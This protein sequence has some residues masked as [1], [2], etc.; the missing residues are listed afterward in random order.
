[1][2]LPLLQ[3]QVYF[4][5]SSRRI[6]GSESI[7]GFQQLWLTS[8]VARRSEPMN[9]RHE[10]V[11]FDRLGEVELEPGFTHPIHIFPS[12]ERGERQGRYRSAALRCTGPELPEE[13]VAVLFRHGDVA[14]EHVGPS[15]THNFQRG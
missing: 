14:D 9:T 8:A 4:F 15:A 7:G 5:S 10:N 3:A 2:S 6:N 12:G 1:M 11:G 13:R